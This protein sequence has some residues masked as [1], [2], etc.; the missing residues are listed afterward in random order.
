VDLPAYAADPARLL[1]GPSSVKLDIG[2]SRRILQ[3][4]LNLD[5]AGARSAAHE[6]GPNT[7]ARRVSDPHATP[8]SHYRPSGGKRTLWIGLP[9]KAPSFEENAIAQLWQLFYGPFAP[10][11]EVA[12]LHLTS[13]RGRATWASAAF[14]TASRRRSTLRASTSSIGSSVSSASRDSHRAALG[15]AVGAFRNATAHR[16]EEY[17]RTAHPELPDAI[18]RQPVLASAHGRRGAQHDSARGPRR[19][20]VKRARHGV[21]LR[22][23]RHKL[24]HGQPAVEGARRPAPLRRA[25]QVHGPVRRPT[26]DQVPARAAGGWAIP[27]GA[28]GAP[29]LPTVLQGRA[30]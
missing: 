9:P 27:A 13:A 8:L 25:H 1:N 28:V 20:P 12:L 18:S 2:S 6:V 3:R 21:H 15:D 29:V 22:A 23:G 24:A 5:L 17:L 26:R 30:G 7:H 19:E 16:A 14:E 11:A 10:L 4:N